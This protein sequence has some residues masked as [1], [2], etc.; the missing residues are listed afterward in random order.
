MVKEAYTMK[1]P[2]EKNLGS[3]A[4]VRLDSILGV[5]PFVEFKNSKT[6]VVA[7]GARF[8]VVVDVVISGRPARLLVKVNFFWNIN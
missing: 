4:K 6:N 5:I 2:L 3:V 7:G 1:K 8:D